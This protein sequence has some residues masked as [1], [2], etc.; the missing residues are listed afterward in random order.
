MLKKTITILPLLVA[1]IFIFSQQVS[2]D[3]TK[4]R[5]DSIL[6]ESKNEYGNDADID[7]DLLFKDMESFLDSIISPRS[8]FMGSV[9]MGKGFFNFTSKSN[10]FIET[11]QKLTYT[12]TLGYFHKGG[13][14]IT[15][16]GNIINH[17]DNLNLYQ[18]SI[19][20][21]YDYLKNRDL[22]TGI[23]LTK[24]FPHIHHAS[25]DYLA[26]DRIDSS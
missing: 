21:G 6:K 4:A 18:F 8:Y 20:P 7:Y 12:P 15:G 23:T 11:A 16:T 22:A 14:S 26:M 25:C 10:F 2:I 5:K 1:G 17:D 24:F 19:S 13:L 9:A 3:T